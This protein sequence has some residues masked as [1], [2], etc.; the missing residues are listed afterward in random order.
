VITRSLYED[1]R[2]AMHQRTVDDPNWMK[3]RRELVEHPF[4]TMK[5]SMGYPRFLVRGRKKAK[6][7][8][9]LTVLGFNLKR[10]LTIMG[11]PA[12]LAALQAAP[13]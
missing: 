2:Q 11:V 1:A 9:A 7:E 12:L 5:W 13:A 8:L 3:R 6:A 4:A 10:T